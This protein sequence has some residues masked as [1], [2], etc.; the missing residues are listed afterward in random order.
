MAVVSAKASKTPERL[1]RS[2]SII[3]C[4]HT[5]PTFPHVVPSLSYMTAAVAPTLT[6]IHSIHPSPLTPHAAKTVG[7]EEEEN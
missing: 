1:A 3:S 5:F 2:F 4:P 7:Q 6:P